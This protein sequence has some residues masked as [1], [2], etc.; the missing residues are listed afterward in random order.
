MG[1][2]GQPT[3]LGALA[4]LA[5]DSCRGSFPPD[6]LPP[7]RDSRGTPPPS[8][9]SCPHPEVALSLE[10]GGDVRL[11]EHPILPRRVIQSFR[12]P[13]QAGEGLGAQDGV[14][15]LLGRAGVGQAV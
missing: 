13:R 8:R 6:T 10:Q 3:A 9:G 1:P 4:Q 5:C 7:S 15:A 12:Q 11:P 2:R 14:E